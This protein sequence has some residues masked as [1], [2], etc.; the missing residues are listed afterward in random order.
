ML[1]T[2]KS[3]EGV[4]GEGGAQLEPLPE[5][6]GPLAGNRAGAMPRLFGFLGLGPGP[7]SSLSLLVFEDHEKTVEKKSEQSESPLI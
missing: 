5:S 1:I 2:S 7:G 3:G 4:G 6:K